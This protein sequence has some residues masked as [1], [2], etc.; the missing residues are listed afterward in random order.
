MDKTELAAQ[1]NTLMIR[2]ISFGNLNKEDEEKIIQESFKLIK[3]SMNSIANMLELEIAVREQLSIMPLFI[4][5]EQD[6]E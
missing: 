3:S 5:P 6:Y 1:L 2:C 4:N